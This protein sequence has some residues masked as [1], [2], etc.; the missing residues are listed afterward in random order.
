MRYCRDNELAYHQL[1]YWCG[2]S[3]QSDKTHKAVESNFVSVCV[4]P[5]Q[6][7]PVATLSLELPNGITITGV[8]GETMA[9][10]QPL[11]RT[12]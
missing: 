10:V 8:N 4:S 5:V 12:L 6:N 1:I 3:A 9:W 11:L 2:K 7:K